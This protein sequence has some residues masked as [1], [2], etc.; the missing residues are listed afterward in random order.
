MIHYA[1]TCNNAHGFDGWFGSSDA[2]ADQQ[3]RGLVTC[4]V[5]ASSDVQK[6]LMA[7]AVAQPR[8]EMASFS[9][10]RPDQAKLRDIMRALREKVTSEA[11]Y[12]GDRFAEEARRIHFEEAPARGIYGE[13][14]REDVAGLIEDGV[15]F[16]PLP[17]LPDEHN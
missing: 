5:C 15:D 2:F 16:L 13:A 12:V 8:A 1:L 9:A 17:G 10:G 7:P 3:A 11:D 4:P 14:T 6:A